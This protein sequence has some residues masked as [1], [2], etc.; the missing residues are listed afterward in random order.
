MLINNE[1]EIVNT[2]IQFNKLTL[3][4]EKT[5]GMIFH[6]RHKIEHIKWSMNNR[7]ID[8]VSKFYFLGVIL[9]EHLSWK[10][11]VNIANNKLSK[12]SGVI[13]RLKYVSL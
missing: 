13:N 8:I 6:K 9:D 10:E 3:N 7:K 12:I 11:H 1:L 5:K 2:W 4:V